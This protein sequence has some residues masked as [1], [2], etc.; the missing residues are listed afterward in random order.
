MTGWNCFCSEF[1]SLTY[2]GP[3]KI[4][5]VTACDARELE[6]IRLKAEEAGG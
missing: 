4:G 1:K 5:P 3:E 6:L 2:E